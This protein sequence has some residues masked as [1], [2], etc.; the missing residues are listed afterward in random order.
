MVSRLLALTL[1][2]LTLL[3]PSALASHDTN[4]PW[5]KS[6]VTV[7]DWTSARAGTYARTVVA[8]WQAALGTGLTLHYER[9]DHRENCEGVAW[10]QGVIRICDY[11]PEA[12]EAA[13]A[14]VGKTNLKYDWNSRQKEWRITGAKVMLV[15]NSFQGGSGSAYWWHP[16]GCHEM[17]HALGL[18]HWYVEDQSCMGTQM[19]TPGP[20]DLTALKRMYG[21]RGH[22][23]AD[24]PQMCCD[25]LQP[26]QPSGE[27]ERS[28]KK[29]GR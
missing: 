14:G 23:I 9:K 24:P 2:A 20:H 27:S 7:E 5:R 8:N 16:L 26:I 11:T 18:N 19:Q 15:A 12:A 6:T 10:Q 22:V 17:G 1:L 3:A 13:G 21:G 4:K 25:E 28:K 29:R